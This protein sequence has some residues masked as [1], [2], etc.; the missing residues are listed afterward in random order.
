MDAHATYAVFAARTDDPPAGLL[1]RAGV[2]RLDP[3]LWRLAARPVAAGDPLLEVLRTLA[4]ERE[5][6]IPKRSYPKPHAFRQ[7]VTVEVA[8]ADSLH[9]DALAFAVGAVSALVAW[10]DGPVVDLT[11]ERVWIRNEWRRHFGPAGRPKPFAVGDHVSVHSS[12]AT[13]GRSATLHTHGMGKFAHPELAALDVPDEG[14]RAVG[15]LLRHLAAVRAALLE[16]L[17]PGHAFDPGFGQPMVAFV[18][19]DPGHP[20]VDHLGAAPSVVVD[21]DVERDEAVDGLFTLLREAKALDR[22]VPAERPRRPLA[23]LRSG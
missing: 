5:P 18:P 2:P 7:A 19:A 17:L 20:V 6:P 23:P 22:P 10:A 21:Y 1:H 15:Q 9:P 13:D 8:R 12:W 3:A 16:P 4:Y 14:T 11:A